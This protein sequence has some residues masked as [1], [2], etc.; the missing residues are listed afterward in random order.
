LLLT[1][2]N[3]ASLCSRIGLSETSDII[4]TDKTDENDAMC[5]ALRE[6]EEMKKNPSK[7][8][9]YTDIDEMMRDLLA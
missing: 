3:Q 7:Y 4:E 2:Q 9:G 6:V 8:Q 5:A 1:F